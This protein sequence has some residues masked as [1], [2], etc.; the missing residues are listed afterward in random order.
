MSIKVKDLK[1]GM[2]FKYEEVVYTFEW[3]SMTGFGY[4]F[5]HDSHK[6][7]VTYKGI[8]QLHV[9]EKGKPIEIEIHEY[10]TN[11]GNAPTD[12]DSV[13]HMVRGFA[14]DTDLYEIKLIEIEEKN[15]TEEGYIIYSKVDDCAIEVMDK[16]KEMFSWTNRPACYKLYKTVVEAMKDIKYAQESTEESLRYLR[17]IYA[18]D[19]LPFINA[20]LISNRLANVAVY[21]MQR[22]LTANIEEI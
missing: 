2:K 6:D 20:K 13:E 21:K 11:Y 22:S 7:Y 19:D 10:I 8:L 9:Q 14:P 16:Q 3:Y 17:H 12:K 15:S 4:D 1:P 5:W 18:E